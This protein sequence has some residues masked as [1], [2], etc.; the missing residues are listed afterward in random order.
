MC[1]RDMSDRA[2]KIASVKYKNNSAIRQSWKCRD[3]KISKYFF[4]T[5]IH[6]VTTP[7]ASVPQFCIKLD[8]FPSGENLSTVFE[9]PKS[10][11]VFASYLGAKKT[12]KKF[13]RSPTHSSSSPNYFTKRSPSSSQK[14]SDSVWT[15]EIGRGVFELRERKEKVGRSVGCRQTRA[16]TWLVVNHWIVAMSPNGSR[17]APDMLPPKDFFLS[18]DRFGA[19]GRNMFQ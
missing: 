17:L 6:G 15:I 5:N 14:L 10:I 2:L 7:N 19:T 16:S 12:R 18:P 13:S 4:F 3:L 11:K 9:R 1:S 8:L